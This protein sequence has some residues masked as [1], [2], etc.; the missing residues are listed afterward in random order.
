MDS[1][2]ASKGG[3]GMMLCY[4]CYAAKFKEDK[5]E[6]FDCN[7]ETREKCENCGLSGIFVRQVSDLK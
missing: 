4:R 6:T 2:N 3:D 7:T 5:W 1:R